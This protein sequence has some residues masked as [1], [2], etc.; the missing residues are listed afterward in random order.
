[1]HESND[2]RIKQPVMEVS[3]ARVTSTCCLVSETIKIKRRAAKKMGDPSINAAG[4]A[5]HICVPNNRCQGNI[6]VSV[7]S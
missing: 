4:A 2:E 1:M 5:A 3:R 7:R 6:F